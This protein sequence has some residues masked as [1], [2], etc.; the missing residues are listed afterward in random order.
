MQYGEKVAPGRWL[1]DFAYVATDGFATAEAGEGGEKAE[2]AA[3][4]GV[5]GPS[6]GGR[7]SQAHRRKKRQGKGVMRDAQQQ[8]SAGARRTAQAK[9]RSPQSCVGVHRGGE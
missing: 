2:N 8:P 5:P 1:V 9:V 6:G 3:G 4:G 7:L